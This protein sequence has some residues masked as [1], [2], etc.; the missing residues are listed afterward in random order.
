MLQLRAAPCSTGHC[1]Q[2]ET[3][4]G[5][6]QHSRPSMLPSPA[7]AVLSASPALDQVCDINDLNVM[8]R[9]VWRLQLHPV[10]T[11]L[12][13]FTA[14]YPGCQHLTQCNLMANDAFVLILSE[15]TVTKRGSRS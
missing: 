4:M 6:M 9:C 15:R 11:L 5:P 3:D 7:V 12:G 1:L 13:V 14:V 2:V 10:D 8:L